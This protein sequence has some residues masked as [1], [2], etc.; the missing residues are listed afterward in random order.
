MW[1]DCRGPSERPKPP[2]TSN[3]ETGKGTPPVLEELFWRS[4]VYGRKNNGRAHSRRIPDLETASAYL[5]RAAETLS[6]RAGI[7][8]SY[9]AECE[10]IG[11]Y[12]R[13]DRGS[14]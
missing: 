6:L 3:S 2:M 4:Q 7:R 8:D 14:E 5:A 11:P 13:S 12:W 9:C 1:R 10:R